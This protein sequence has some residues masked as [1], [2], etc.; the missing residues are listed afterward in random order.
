[1][2]KSH[3]QSLRWIHRLYRR[4][5]IQH[6]VQLI[7]LG[8]GLAILAFQFFFF[9]SILLNYHYSGVNFLF[10]SLIGLLG[11]F[12]INS[13]R[14]WGSEGFRI[15]SFFRL[16]E[17]R[18]PEIANRASLLVYAEQNADEIQR[19]GYSDELIHADDE[20]LEKYIHSKTLPDR[21]HT[22]VYTLIFFFAA[23]V[24]S[25]LFWN[26]K[27]DFV[28][29]EWKSISKALWVVA[30]PIVHDTITV[31]ERIS[32]ARGEPVT[33]KASWSNPD[34]QKETSVFFR[35]RNSWDQQ[36]VQLE[37]NE[38]VL[39]IPAVNREMEFYFSAETTLSN[40]GKI[41]PLDPPS[42]AEGSMTVSPPAYTGLPVQTL[43][44]LRPLSMPEG[45]TVHISAK[46]T[47]A[48]VSAY[49]FFN[50]ASTELAVRDDFFETT[51]RINQPGDL[52]FRM[53]DAHGLIGNSRKY[54]LTAVP[55]A[56]PSLEIINP[57]PI[58]DM[59]VDM[60][61]KV[62]AH[63]HDDYRLEKLFKHVEIN[64]QKTDKYTFMVWSNNPINAASD[65]QVSV[66]TELFV[67]YDWNLIEYRLF[68]GDEVTFSLEI[69]DN[70]V[71]HGPK[72][73][74]TQNYVVKYPSLVDLLSQLDKMEEK[75]T[76]DLSSVVDKQKQITEDAKKTIE[77][78][79][80]KIEKS[81][82][83]T[84]EENENTWMEEKEMES[85]KERQQELVEEAQKIEEQLKEYKEKAQEIAQKQEEQQKGITPETLE[86][87]E[88]IQQLMNQLVDQDSKSLMEKIDQTID[89]MSQKVT[90]EQL[91]DLNFSFEDY[92]QQLERT[93]SMLE[94]AF[95]SRQLEGLKQMAEEMAQRQD[96]LQRETQKLEEDQQ[97]L[98][99][100]EQNGN[101][102]DSE[103]LEAKKK[104]LETQKNLLEKRQE[105]LE[106]DAQ[107][108][109]DAMQD[110]KK[111]ME[112][113]NPAVAQKL[114]QMRQEAEEKGLK[115]EMSQA[116]E[117]VKSN[118]LS[119]A[120]QNQKN[121]AKQ[122]QSMAQ[123]MQEQ[124][125]DMGGMEMQMDTAA[126]ARLIQQGLFLSYQLENLTESPLG[127]SD[128][129]DALRRAQMFQRELGRI[130][131]AWKEIAKTNPFMNRKVENGLRTSGQ[132]LQKAVQAGQG[133]RW[134]GL[135]EARGSMGALNDAIFQM[136]QD[137][138]NM[139]QQ[140]S[141]SQ[142][143]GMQQQMQQMIS[144]Q[145]TL[146]QMLQQMREMSKPGE[147][148][149]DEM[150]QMAQQQ[151]KI[152]KEIEKMMQQYRHAQQ[153]RNQLDGIYQEMKDVEKL[154]Q[155]GTNDENVEEKQ[156]RIMTR[157][158]EAGTTQ[159]NEDFGKDRE[160]EV[161]K[162]G[163]DAK[164]PETTEPISLP[165]KI[166][167]FIKRPDTESIPLP[168]REALKKYYIRLSEQ[169]AF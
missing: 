129:L 130:D 41:I 78:L 28:Q 72:S 37:G 64:G 51:L 145:Q 48:L 80:D 97:Q 101:P 140:S 16:W 94:N 35:T 68:P 137:M 8:I 14:T 100:A 67:N 147:Q 104:E 124:I 109:M 161:A 58:S 49:A 47:S 88:K 65:A 152:R 102:E 164:P 96:H 114:D 160:E 2:H 153:L 27:S 17:H 79:S 169:P 36:S 56:T 82:Q 158:L 138:Q 57:K 25:V 71:L 24:P 98:S 13:L 76:E 139:Q 127:R 53:E 54:R 162:T 29:E 32:V 21:R 163:L 159:E 50:D 23:S 115:K 55:D 141:S 30:E 125:L 89:Q 43:D 95:Q 123:Q 12:L 34:S 1:M 84:D 77:K 119:Q 103:K 154:L 10:V 167:Q 73:F 20:W 132:R 22:M 7:G 3:W 108:L 15:R 146:Q 166:D 18:R 4:H 86:K 66:T 39:H 9:A 157:M 52:F 107:T 91:K 60:Q 70:D 74:R 122:L 168:Y 75:Q 111:T 142:S 148:M 44:R 106:Q 113:T 92:N 118:Q 93:L 156:K 6:L 143:Q 63:A 62:Q 151:A 112:E 144:Q 131:A 165:E 59:P 126:L 128:A 26:W 40:K 136:M 149:M 31:P 11:L 83:S 81:P 61:L 120:Q 33:L 46:A 69:F 110:M 105:Q 19:L 90:D 155:E 5:V 150:K 99:Q 135:H 134:V 38:L 45:S 117:K 133:E 121:A 116:R 42:L 85:I 87:I